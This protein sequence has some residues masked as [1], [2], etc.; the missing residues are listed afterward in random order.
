MKLVPELAFRVTVPALVSTMLTAPV[1]VAVNEP[2]LVEPVPLIAI[3]PVPEEAVNDAVLSAPVEETA[4]EP[5]GNAVSEIVFAAI[6]AA[7]RVTSPAVEFS[8]ILFAVML[9]PTEAVVIV[10]AAVIFT[11]LAPPAPLTALVKE[12]PPAVEVMFTVLAVM[13]PPVLL[14]LPDEVRETVPIVPAPAARLP[15][16]FKVPDPTVN[17]KLDPLPAEEAFNATAA[18][19]SLTKLTLPVEFADNVEA[20]MVLAP[21]NEMP[22]VPAVKLA[23]GALS[24]PPAAIP[25]PT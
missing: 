8:A 18:A 22:A 16:T 10:F 19:V 13:V 2:A 23:V 14:W 21:A 9:P 20:F 24:E 7:V 1:E 4:P 5:P 17:P 3:P 15:A 25:L 12:T 11:W 6:K